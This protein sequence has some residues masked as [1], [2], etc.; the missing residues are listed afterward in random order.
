MDF[1]FLSANR[2][3]DKMPW[4]KL[5]FLALGLSILTL[6]L[7]SIDLNEIGF[8]IVTIHLG[9]ILLGFLFWIFSIAIDTFLWRMALKAQNIHPLPFVELFFLHLSAHM[10]GL[11]VPG[12]GVV[13]ENSIKLKIGL[14]RFGGSPDQKTERI[15]SSFTYVIY[16]ASIG[17]IP[18]LILMT[19]LLINHIELPTEISI[20]FLLFVVLSSVFIGLI[21]VLLSFYP[22]I[23]FSIGKWFSFLFYNLKLTRISNF[24]KNQYPSLIY[25]YQ[26]S[27]KELFYQKWL[28]AASVSI[29]LLKRAFNFLT[30]FSFYAAVKIVPITIIIFVEFLSGS[31]NLLPIP[32]P[33]MVGLIESVTGKILYL[34][35]DS[36]TEP[37]SILASILGRLPFYIGFSVAI[38]YFLFNKQPLDK[39]EENR[40]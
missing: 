11:T 15:I 13:I 21:I 28:L 19:F 26:Q 35:S 3:Y 39:I 31:A 10:W 30:L 33:G 4:K 7:Y 32:I 20:L 25:Q 14:E 29:F 17:S 6:Y 8:L 23:L 9:F 24:F 27:F 22:G 40:V 18:V 38:F 12:G 1:I 16:V 37:E 5:I 34:I 36:L 2:L